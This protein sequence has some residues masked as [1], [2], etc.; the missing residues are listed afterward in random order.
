MHQNSI[1]KVIRDSLDA[2]SKKQ[3]KEQVI[4]I[5][6]QKERDYMKSLL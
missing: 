6:Q 5:K 2:C 4:T 1:N 3:K